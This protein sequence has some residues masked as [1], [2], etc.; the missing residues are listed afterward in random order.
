MLEIDQVTA[1]PLER[2]TERAL[3]RAQLI[4]AHLD[5][6]SKRAAGMTPQDVSRANQPIGDDARGII[7]RP[8]LADIVFPC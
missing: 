6:D 5:L 3:T 8:R 2:I 7:E 1:R 4:A